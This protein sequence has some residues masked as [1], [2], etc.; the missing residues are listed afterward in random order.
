MFLFIKTLSLTTI[1]SKKIASWKNT[2][3]S[4][5]FPNHIHC[6]N[7][8]FKCSPGVQKHQ[9]SAFLHPQFS[10][11]SVCSHNTDMVQKNHLKFS[12]WGTA[13]SSVW[14]HEHGLS[15]SART[16]ALSTQTSA[17]YKWLAHQSRNKQKSVFFIRLKSHERFGDALGV[18]VVCE[19]ELCS[20]DRLRVSRFL[21]EFDE[22]ISIDV[23]EDVCRRFLAVRGVEPDAVHGGT[24][25]A[26]AW[27]CVKRHF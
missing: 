10:H 17:K 4:T 23:L 14:M 19:D 26:R 20:L 22:H 18:L 1:Y 5:F 12:I 24:D 9:H 11:F 25:A 2:G 21:K 27:G 13:A 16:C 3:I 6:L 8:Y 7:L 15:L